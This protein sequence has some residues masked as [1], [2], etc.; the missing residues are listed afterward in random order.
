[1]KYRLWA[2]GDLQT[3]LQSIPFSCPQSPA[4]ELVQATAYVQI[5]TLFTTSASASRH[6]SGNDAIS[7]RRSVMVSD[8]YAELLK[9]ES[10]TDLNVQ[11]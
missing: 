2:V 9:I 10:G 6:V 8:N 7:Y 5:F 4:L 1:V 3:V 11:P